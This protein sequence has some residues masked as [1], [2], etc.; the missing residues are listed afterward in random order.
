MLVSLPEGVFGLSEMMCFDYTLTIFPPKWWE[1]EAYHPCCPKES[2]QEIFE[3]HFFGVRKIRLYK[4]FGKNSTVSK[5]Y[6][7]RSILEG[8]SHLQVVDDIYDGFFDTLH[9]FLDLKTSPK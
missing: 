1:P 8:I 2:C 5:I 6:S 3:P 9:N 7:M 4:R